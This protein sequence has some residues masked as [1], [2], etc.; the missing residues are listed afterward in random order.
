MFDWDKFRNTYL[1]LPWLF[2]LVIGDRQFDMVL[3]G[4]PRSFGD[5][6]QRALEK[7]LWFWPRVIDAT[8]WA[9]GATGRDQTPLNYTVVDPD[10]QLLLD[11]IIRTCPDK[12]ASLLD[13]GC[14]TG[15][16][17]I[18]L[19]E[20]GYRNLTGVDA[21][22]E[23][24]SF[25]SQRAPDVFRNARIN[26]DL[27]QRFLSRQADRSFDLSYSHGATIELVHPSFDVVRHLTRVTRS[28]ICLLLHQR[29]GFRRHWFEQFARN[30]F[31]LIHDQAVPPL[32]SEMHLVVFKRVDRS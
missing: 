26:H 20:R 5:K 9:R 27:F 17:V 4:R 22:G 23:A 31:E 18:Y 24:I 8:P 30:G 6:I 14:N 21:M 15:R 32:E 10:A 19:A 2:P 12:N 7:M 1:Q 13:V 25:F 28:H 3:H 29:H 16:H 11:A